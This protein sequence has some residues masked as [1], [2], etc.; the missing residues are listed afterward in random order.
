MKRAVVLTVL[1]L[2][3]F[4]LLPMPQASGYNQ[5][6]SV[7]GYILTLSRDGQAVMGMK[8]VYILRIAHEGGPAVEKASVRA[9]AYHQ[10]ESGFLL[11]TVGGKAA[12]KVTP[13]GGGAYR[14]EAVYLGPGEGRL[15]LD[16]N[17]DGKS[18][19]A[20]FKDDVLGLQ[21]PEGEVISRGEGT[22]SRAWPF[23]VALLILA[24]IGA[25]HRRG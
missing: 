13:M 12:T 23:F 1:F 19:K 5:A 14:V 24:A 9:L 22:G 21:E 20:E 8:T 6:Q 2:F 16:V 10:V 17:L 7:D 3:L 18:I 25:L 11:C 15:K 4:L